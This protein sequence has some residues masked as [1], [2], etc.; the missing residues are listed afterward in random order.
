MSGD[1]ISLL[2]DKGLQ[3]FN[4]V[5]SCTP[6]VMHFAVDF[7]VILVEVPSSVCVTL[8]A[9]NAFTSDFHDEHWSEPIPPE[10]D[11]S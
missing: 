8:H 11:V 5:A 4:L 7:H 9:V 1:I 6:Q 3:H 2:V 10:P